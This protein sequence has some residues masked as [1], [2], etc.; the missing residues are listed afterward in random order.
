MHLATFCASLLLAAATTA[1]HAWALHPQEGEPPAYPFEIVPVDALRGHLMDGPFKEPASA[2]FEPVAGEL[3]VADMKN[4]LIGIFEP[5]GTPLFAFGGR[6]MLV[7]PTE[8]RVAAD[9]TIYVLDAARREIKAF[10]YR[11]E[12]LQ[13]LGFPYPAIGDRSEGIARIGAFAIGGDGRWYVGDLNVPQVLVYDAER[14]F[15][16]AV[17]GEDDIVSFKVISGIA[18]SSEGLIAVVD[19][20]GTPV[21]VFDSRGRFVSGFGT[22]ELGIDSFTAP[23]DVAFDEEGRLFVVDM[24][25]HDVRIFDVGG[26]MLGIFG[27]WFGRGSGGRAPGELLYPNAIA[28]APGGAIYVS[29]RFGNRVQVFE[30]LPLGEDAGRPRLRIPSVNERR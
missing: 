7:D 5:D 22:R 9:G 1:L 10:N 14:R 11:G 27:G 4:A 28:L 2:F 16:F 17:P 19:Q 3:F 30:R 8:V 23:A 24:L 12:V 26:N 15:Q 21:Q 13:P 20:Q 18:V 6:P 29:E 25:R